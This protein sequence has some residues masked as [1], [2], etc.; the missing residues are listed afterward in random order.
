MQDKIKIMTGNV[1]FGTFP[2][3][4]PIEKYCSQLLPSMTW[5]ITVNNTGGNLS[6]HLLHFYGV[7]KSQIIVLCYIY[8][9][10][11][12]AFLVSC[13]F[14]K[15]VRKVG[16]V[17]QEGCGQQVWQFY[18]VVSRKLWGK[19]NCAN[20]HLLKAC[21]HFIFWLKCSP[22]CGKCI[23]GCAHFT[24]MYWIYNEQCMKHLS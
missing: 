17:Y 20:L 15:V 5:L 14:S 21:V 1:F 18:N 8:L 13:H 2:V 4:N 3:R 10:E 22:R 12:A 11:F 24:P 16:G 6:S 23:M 19:K 9:L 7:E